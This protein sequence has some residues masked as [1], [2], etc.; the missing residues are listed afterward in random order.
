M[1]RNQIAPVSTETYAVTYDTGNGERLVN[2]TRVHLWQQDEDGRV[3]GLYAIHDNQLWSTAQDKEFQ[4]YII[5]P[6]TEN[7]IEKMKDDLKKDIGDKIR[8]VT[9]YINNELIWE[10][11]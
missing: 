10:S 5:G 9:L 3:F 1:T 4:E 6:I 2:V 8:V 7:V 11:E